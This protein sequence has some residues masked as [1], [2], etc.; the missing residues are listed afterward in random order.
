MKFHRKIKALLSSPATENSFTGII[1]VLTIWLANLFS[2]NNNFYYFS[3]WPS[4]VSLRPLLILV[5][6]I[7]PLLNSHGLQTF[8][9]EACC[10]EKN[11]CFSTSRYRAW[12][13]VG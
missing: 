7:F 4:P 11:L 13:V 5:F 8:G 2:R 10:D 12:V 3:I 1:W 9:T 6:Y